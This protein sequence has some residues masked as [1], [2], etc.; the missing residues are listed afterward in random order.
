VPTSVSI[1]IPLQPVSKRLHGR[2]A[3]AAPRAL[4]AWRHRAGSGMPGLLVR[5]RL[6]TAQVRLRLQRGC[7]GRE[8]DD[9]ASVEDGQ[10]SDALLESKRLA[11][12]L[13]ASL[14]F[15]R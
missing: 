12:V 5:R 3:H 6:D 10:T 15:C 2:D 1:N 11:R 4:A 8:Q 7:V 9:P 14:F 13:L